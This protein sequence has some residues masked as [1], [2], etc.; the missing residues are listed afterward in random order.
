MTGAVGQQL[1]ASNKEVE[2]GHGLIHPLHHASAEAVRLYEF[3]SGSEVR[4]ADLDRPRA[5]FRSLFNLRENTAARDVIEEGRSFSITDE[6]DRGDRDFRQVEWRHVHTQ[7]ANH[8]ERLLIIRTCGSLE[9]IGDRAFQSRPKISNSHTSYVS[10]RVPVERHI[11]DG[12]VLAV[13]SVDRIE[14]ESA[15]FG[16]AANRSDGI[17]RPCQHHAAMTADAPE[18]RT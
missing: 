11:D 17:L 6:I 8:T 9:V 5:P 14:D 15:I 2:T 7:R 18:R 12:V 16:G 1:L 13:G 4:A 3:H 10:R